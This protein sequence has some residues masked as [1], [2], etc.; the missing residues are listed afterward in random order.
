MNHS[1]LE[2]DLLLFQLAT[3]K[4]G[5]DEPSIAIIFL[6]NPLWH[7][8]EVLQNSQVLPE[9]NLDILLLPI[10]WIQYTKCVHHV[11]GGEEAGFD[12]VKH[13]NNNFYI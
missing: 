2:D 6:A 12:F 11:I 8:I 9:M 10:L 4:E 7:A 3:I 1:T 5:V 13:L